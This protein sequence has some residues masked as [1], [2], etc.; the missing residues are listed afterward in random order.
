MR[1]AVSSAHQGV[2]GGVETYLRW[3]MPALAARGHSIAFLYSYPAVDSALRIDGEVAHVWKTSDGGAEQLRAWKPDVVYAHSLPET[4]LDLSLSR[5]FPTVF[6]A[7][8]YYAACASGE[9]RHRLPRLATCERPF[10]AACLALN[11]ARGCG[12]RR[13]DRLLA[14]FREG[15][16]QQPVLQQAR[17]LVVASEHMRRVYEREGLASGRISVLPYPTLEQTPLPSP[18][19]ARPQTGRLLF[20]GRLTR[21]KGCDRAILAT[22][23]A[24]RL[25]GRHLRLDVA[26]AGPDE[27]RCRALAGA[28]VDVTFHGW[29]DGEAKRKLVAGADLLLVPSLWPEPFGIVG[30]EAGCFGVPSVGFPVGGIPDWL[31]PGIN[32]ELGPL[33]SFDVPALAQ[34]IVRALSDRE[35]HQALRLGAWRVAQE[36]SPNRHVT[37]LGQVLEHAKRV[38]A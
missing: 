30:I 35:Y 12:V 33:G 27:H 25:L 31:R 4:E 9:R 8:A 36:Y 5:D 6:F 1:V 26:G 2:V 10:S 34:A 3:L 13:P 23:L 37:D 21:Q 7:H 19:A 16:R 18:P 32:G 29:I 14:Q 20:L 24:S 22:A 15:R 11:F 28:D 17:H 38:S